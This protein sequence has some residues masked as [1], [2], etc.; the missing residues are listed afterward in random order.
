NQA[1]RRHNEER[2][3]EL[4]IRAAASE[5]E[6]AQVHRRLTALEGELNSNRQLL[7]SAA[8]EVAAAQLEL[9]AAQQQANLTNTSVAGLERQ[10]EQSRIAILEAVSTVSTLR[11]QLTQAEERMAAAARESQRLESEMALANAQAETFGGERG[12]LAIEF[13]SVSQKVAALSGEI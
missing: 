8:A 2:C 11:N 6:L 12:Q 5:A 7:D 4:M 3:N 13:E 1:Q 9:A 10:Q